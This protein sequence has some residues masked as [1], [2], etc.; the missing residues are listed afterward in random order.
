[1][2]QRKDNIINSMNFDD[3]I[4]YVIENKTIAFSY[5]PEKE[6]EKPIGAVIWVIE[7]DEEIK[8]YMDD[9]NLENYRLA[10]ADGQ[11]YSIE[12]GEDFYCS[13]NL[14]EEAKILT[15]R[16]ANCE[17]ISEYFFYQIQIILKI[18][19]GYSIDEAT[20]DNSCKICDENLFMTGCRKICSKCKN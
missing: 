6:N 19:A 1:M 4:R 12:R 3:A 17:S 2:N 13:D 11:F 5:T 20:D 8:E 14:P 10:Y 15:Y 7:Y 18:L 16:P 9:E